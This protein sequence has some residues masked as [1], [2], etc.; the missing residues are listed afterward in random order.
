MNILTVLG[1]GAYYAQ[2]FNYEFIA[3]AVSIVVVIGV[4]YGTLHIT[5]FPTYIIAGITAW[6]VMHMMG[7]SI[8]TADGVLYAWKMLPIYDGG[9]EF[10]IL[11]FDQF[12]HAFLYGVVALMFYHLLREVVRIRTHSTFI[13]VVSVFAAA[14][15]SIINEVIEFLAVVALPETGVGG[16][17]N[18]VLDMLFNLAGAAIAILVYR[19]LWQ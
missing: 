13:A 6:A 4:L 11:K 17:Y 16:Y 18:T 14:G 12:V 2:A 3:Y 8:Q 7:G 5:R 9:G 10:Y 1:F 15:V 19:L